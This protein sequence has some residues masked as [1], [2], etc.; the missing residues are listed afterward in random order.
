MSVALS[1]HTSSLPPP[2]RLLARYRG[3][4]F[5]EERFSWLRGE[6]DELF[7]AHYREASADLSIPLDVRWDMYENLELAGL[8]VCAVIRRD[9]ALIGYVVYIV[10]PHLHYQHTVADIDVFFIDP[11]HRKGWLGVRLF[12]IAETLLR[13]R[14]VTEVCSRIKLHVKPGRG[15]RD[16]GALFRW[17]GYRP[18]ETLYRK[19]IQ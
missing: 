3:Y 14:G 4:S 11:A 2:P 17:L 12:Q 15:T 16:L 10:V 7:E 18:V 13:P 6:G 5:H 9:S 19:R 1:A 8:E